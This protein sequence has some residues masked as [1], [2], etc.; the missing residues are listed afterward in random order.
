MKHSAK[1]NGAA[2]SRIRFHC[3]AAQPQPCSLSFH[4]KELTNAG[5]VS[6]ERDGR[7]LIYRAA[8]ERMNGLLACLT[9]NCCQGTAC[10]PAVKPCSSC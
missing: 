7:H 6:R 5:L 4:L 10:L 8:F 1:R 9:E 2:L 3:K